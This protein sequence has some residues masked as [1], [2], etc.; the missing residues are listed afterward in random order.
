MPPLSRFDRLGAKAVQ[1][2]RRA[3]DSVDAGVVDTRRP[4]TYDVMIVAATDP[5]IASAVPP[6][7]KRLAALREARASSALVSFSSVAMYGDTAVTGTSAAAYSAASPA[8]LNPSNFPA[9]VAAGSEISC[10]FAVSTGSLIERSARA[11]SA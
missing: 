5:V 3:G 1:I 7:V 6:T 2:Q 9:R 4:A 11:I 8:A 10:S